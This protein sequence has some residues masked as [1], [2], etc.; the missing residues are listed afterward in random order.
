MHLQN[1]VFLNASCRDVLKLQCD[2]KVYRGAN[3]KDIRSAPQ[4]QAAKDNWVGHCS[5]GLCMA[6][7]GQH[8]ILSSRTA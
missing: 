8:F 4:N 2:L 1:Q 3:K 7:R 5:L 6:H